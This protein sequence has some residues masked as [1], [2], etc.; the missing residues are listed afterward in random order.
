M[1]VAKA[2]AG[3]IRG[4]LD[5]MDNELADRLLLWLMGAIFLVGPLVGLLVG[6]IRG[7]QWGIG[8]ACLIIGVTG[9]TGA[10]RVGWE[11]WHQLQGTVTSDG[12]LVEFREEISRDAK[13]RAVSSYAPVVRFTDPAGTSHEIKGLGGSQGNVNQGDPVAVRYRPETPEQAVVA[14]FQNVWGGTVAFSIFG[15]LPTLFG[16]FFVLGNLLKDDADRS[17]DRSAGLSAQDIAL[18]E[19]W[20]GRFYSVGTLTFLAA[21]GVM[22]YYD[23]EGVEKS[24]G[25]GFMTIAAACIPYMIGTFVSTKGRWMQ[26]GVLLIL[27]VGFGLFGGVAWLLG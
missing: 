17:A 12:I 25:L 14:D 16:L 10:V 9:L 18:R 5:V 6:R 15:I 8:V 3:V 27:M 4:K 20:A 21:F 1:G 24:A 22:M 7:I 23:S 11:R 2:G 19:L 26:R 13:G